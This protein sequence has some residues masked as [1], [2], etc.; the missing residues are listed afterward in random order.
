MNA[1]SLV[2]KI[3]NIRNINSCELELDLVP[4]MYA[5]VGEN[6]CG[7]ST[8]MLLLSLCVKSSSIYSLSRV[9]I[10]RESEIE[11]SIDGKV[12]KW[13]Y[14][15]SEMSLVIDKDNKIGRSINFYRGFYEG[16]IF[17]GSRFYDYTLVA[18]VLR[19]EDI[20]D[21]I[22]DADDFVKDSMSYILHGDYE[23]YRTLKKI[24]TKQSAKDLGF[25]GMPYF[26]LKGDTLISQYSM[27]SGES[28]IIS[29][30]DFIN[31]IAI[32]NKPSAGDKILFFI[33]EVELALHPSAIDRLVEFFDGLLKNYN[34]VVYFSSHS[35]EVIQKIEPKNIFL[36][37]NFDGQIISINPCYPNYAIRN[38]Y[39][40][41]GFDFLILVEDDLA[42]AVVEKSIRELKI[43]SSK[44]W[45][46][47]PAGGWYQTA[48]LHHDI[49]KHNVLGVGKKVISIYDGD[50]TD[51]VNKAQEVKN[52]PKT[53]LPIPSVEKYLKKKLIDEKDRIF[54]KTIGDKYFTQKSLKDILLE[55]QRDPKATRD[56][57]GKY[58]YRKL[59]VN[60][61]LNK[62]DEGQFIKYL[63]ED[64]SDFEN[65]ES[66]NEALQELIG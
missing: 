53:F 62:L 57:N 41:N 1:S 34:M 66:F 65:F 50:V 23:H 6:A 39:V 25:K 18:N 38:L 44:L 36:I 49:V 37:E 42:K 55:Y 56:R 26:F 59:S 19:R 35:S 8:I 46:V 20:F 32:R 63:C 58:L 60:L 31:N 30:V 7:K 28:M 10:D 22:R 11:I 12:D 16:S 27:S 48:R 2:L 14:K 15:N 47:M 64:I 24:K 9:D 4:G 17:Y 51:S 43:C 21:Y 3:K 40:P 33:D 29:L 54:I 61:Q 45:C 13:E 5:L 52:L